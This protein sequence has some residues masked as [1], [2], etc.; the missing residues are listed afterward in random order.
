MGLAY[1]LKGDMGGVETFHIRE[2]TKAVTVDF[3]LLVTEDVSF[4]F[5]RQMMHS[6]GLLPRC[7]LCQVFIFWMPGRNILGTRLC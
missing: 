7:Q 5:P 4:Y 1:N 3:E 6:F 2:K